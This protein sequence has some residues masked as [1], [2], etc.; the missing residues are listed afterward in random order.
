M[1]ALEVPPVRRIRVEVRSE[2]VISI[3]TDAFLIVALAR[4]TQKDTLVLV[5]RDVEENAEN[6]ISIYLSYEYMNVTF[7]HTSKV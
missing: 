6:Y 4:T 5:L 7:T 2:T 1:I 3:T